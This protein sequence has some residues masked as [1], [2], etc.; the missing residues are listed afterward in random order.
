VDGALVNPEA[1]ATMVTV[2]GETP[3]ATPLLSIVAVPEKLHAHENTTP[4]MVLPL[5]SKAV[6]VNGCVAF[7]A[8]LVVR[9]ETMIDAIGWVTVSVE[10]ALVTPLVEAVI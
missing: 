6:A 5:T 3:V 7:T 2:P 10:G 9:G 4:E 8:M 1:L